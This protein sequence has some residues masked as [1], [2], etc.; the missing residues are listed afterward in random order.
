VREIRHR[1][2]ILRYILLEALW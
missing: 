1:G 2:P